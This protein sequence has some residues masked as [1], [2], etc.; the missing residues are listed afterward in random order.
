VTIQVS[1]TDARTAKALE[2][3]SGA[4]R[5]LKVTSK[6]D[7]RRYYAI[8]SSDGRHVYWARPDACSCPD[9]T[10]RGVTCKHQIAAG[11]WVAKINVERQQPKRRVLSPSPDCRG[12]AQWANYRRYGGRRL[13]RAERLPCTCGVIPDTFTTAPAVDGT[14]GELA[15]REWLVTLA[16]NTWGRDGEG[17]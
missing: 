11:L 4:D 6:L 17:S 3:L 7:G 1:T 10:H 13:S 15:R 2:L 12:C 14:L 9:A 8:P 5:W 16:T